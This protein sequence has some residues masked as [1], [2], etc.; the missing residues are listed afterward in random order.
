VVKKETHKWSTSKERVSVAC[1]ATK[2]PSIS[3][4]FP[5]AQGP[6][7]RGGGRTARERGLG[8]LKQN[9]LLGMMGPQCTQAH[10]DCSYVLRACKISQSTL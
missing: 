6:S 3:H 4:S 7:K 9:C 10:G 2:G 5:N 8:G 1:L